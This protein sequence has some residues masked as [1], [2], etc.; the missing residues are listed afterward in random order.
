M[1]PDTLKAVV[2]ASSADDILSTSSSLLHFFLALPQFQLMVRD[3]VDPERCV[4]G[5]NKDAALDAK[6]KGNLCFSSA[7]FSGAL[8]FYS[9]ALI[10]APFDARDKDK[11]LVSVLYVNRAVALYKLGF[12]IECLRDCNRALQISPGYAKAWY[13]RGKIN[14]ASENYEDAMAD[15]HVANL[16]ETSSGGKRQIEGEMKLLQVQFTTTSGSLTQHDENI[17]KISDVPHE[18]KVK[19]IVMPHKGRGMASTGEIPPSYLVHSEEPYAAVILKNC[20][21]RYC[22]YCFNELPADVVPCSFCAIPRYCSEHCQLKAGGHQ[23]RN[24][25]EEVS[26]HVEVPTE[27]ENH[28]REVTS[29]NWEEKIPEHFAEHRHECLDANW[30]AVLPHEVVLAGRVVVKSLVQRRDLVEIKALDLSYSYTE[31]AVEV[32]LELCIYAIVLLVCLQRSLSL[33]L[34]VNP[35]FVYQIIIIM[36]QIRLNSMAIIRMKSSDPNAPQDPHRKLSSNEAASASTIEQVSVGQAIYAVGSLFNHSCR[37]N[38]HAY[39]LARTLFIRTTELVE[40]GCSLE[41][42]YGPQVGQWSC[43]DRLKFLGEKYCFRCQC[44][45]CSVVNL[46]DLVLSAFHCVHPHCSGIVLD[47]F[48]IKSETEK[49]KQSRHAGD[50]Y[51]L[52]PYVQVDKFGD[53]YAGEM[54]H[55]AQEKSYS[56]LHAGVGYCLKCGS[57]CDLESSCLMVSKALGNIKRLQDGIVRK[58]LSSSLL[59]NA[60]ES[61][62]QLRK[63]LHAYNKSIAEAEDSIAQAFCFIGELQCAMEHCKSSIQILEKL[64]S[65]DHVVIGYEL[66]KLLSIQLSL[67]DVDAG[68]T[69]NRLGMI[70]EHHYGSHA[71]VVFPYLKSFKREARKLCEVEDS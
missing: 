3:L 55:N 57:H 30:P 71:A 52:E 34:P 53:L 7:D 29:D 2:G 44:R 19:S 31:L 50:I 1:V 41:L 66:V 13:W 38:I 6:Q 24:N 65:P 10:V 9:Q 36:C 4:C 61:L 48:D 15:L 21:D 32:K 42:S 60:L 37:P 58:E 39:F 18:V 56:S 69:L 64:Y 49:L 27:I 40:A 47:T 54:D 67:G 17:F 25:V 22:H 68:E 43:Q 11:N 23:S 20:R 33:D 16:M 35:Y 28:I 5:K 12:K 45:S 63:V 46:S 62:D 59:S 70:F 14:A 26:L 51:S 8:A